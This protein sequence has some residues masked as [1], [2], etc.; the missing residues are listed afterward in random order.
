MIAIASGNKEIIG[1][2]DNGATWFVVSPSYGGAIVSDNRII[3]GGES[4]IIYSD[5]EGLTWDKSSVTEGKWKN[6]LAVEKGTEKRIYAV[7]ENNGVKVSLDNGKTFEETKVSDG[8]WNGLYYDSDANGVIV[9]GN[10][11]AVFL[12]RDND[13]DSKYKNGQVLTP[14]PALIL[15]G[16]VS[17][18]EELDI[19][20]LT[21]GDVD[22]FVTHILNTIMYPYLSMK[23]TGY[24]KFP[25]GEEGVKNKYSQEKVTI[26]S[27]NGISEKYKFESFI[28]WESDVGMSK[29][30]NVTLLDILKDDDDEEYIRN[31][32]VGNTEKNYIETLDSVNRVIEAAKEEVL[33]KEIDKIQSYTPDGLEEVI[34]LSPEE[35][36]DNNVKAFNFYVDTAKKMSIAVRQLIVNK[37]YDLSE[38]NRRLLVR[39]SLY[40]MTKDL[41]GKIKYELIKAI[42]SGKKTFNVFNLG[43]ETN[44]EF[45]LSKSLEQYA[46]EFNNKTKIIEEDNDS[47]V[48]TNAAN[49]YNTIERTNLIE[50][51][52]AIVTKVI[53]N[54]D[55]SNISENYSL[56]EKDLENFI[57]KVSKLDVSEIDEFYHN[58]NFLFND[59]DFDK[60]IENTYLKFY[61]EILKSLRKEIK[62][63]Y[64]TKDFFNERLDNLSETLKLKTIKYIE[65]IHEKFL[66]RCMELFIDIYKNNELVNKKNYIKDNI[67]YSL[68]K[69]INDLKHEDRKK[70]LNEYNIP[71]IKK[72]T[73]KEI[74]D[75]YKSILKDF[76]LR[77]EEI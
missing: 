59:Y 72:E 17:S 26:I 71:S 76:E 37:I 54:F 75:V 22:P 19:S 61:K 68:Y 12:N 66:S 45:N 1:T 60:I 67:E 46:I 42:K 63:I 57:E 15:N 39:N 8:D 9:Y 50:Q 73:K 38:Y 36:L 51:A 70:M 40:E 5:N 32:I 13:T 14:F 56:C 52:V 24:K 18:N 49:F 6:F 28:D 21:L 44:F 58:Y 48:I 25:L 34:R 64:M 4:G 10:D 65:E 23:Y 77:R 41:A 3:S 74:E 30:G 69:W 43:L 2:E 27:P 33:E 35:F 29:I 55:Y 11:G 31:A 20:K 47:G 16:R 53:D 7:S 62:Y